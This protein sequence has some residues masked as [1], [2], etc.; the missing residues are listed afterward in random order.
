[1]AAKKTHQAA[2]RPA[3]SGNKRRTIRKL[4]FETEPRATLTSFCLGRLGKL[5]LDVRLILRF[6]LRCFCSLTS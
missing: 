6:S 1:M 2:F 3:A 5:P 4:H